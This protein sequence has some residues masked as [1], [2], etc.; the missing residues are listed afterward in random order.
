MLISFL[1]F[2]N[3]YAYESTDNKSQSKYERIGGIETYLKNLEKDLNS[4]YADVENNKLE[5][6]KLS[7][8]KNDFE[9]LKTD[10]ESL[11]MNLTETRHL[12]GGTSASRPVAPDDFKKALEYIEKLKSLKIDEIKYQVDV[13]DIQIKTLQKMKKMEG[14]YQTSPSPLVRPTP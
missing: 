1:L 4:L 6:K 5:L 3:L 12:E 9:K 2:F 10:V 14:E 13:H 8:F 11:K 7:S